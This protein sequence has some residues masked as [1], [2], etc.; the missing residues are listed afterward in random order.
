M[1]K[2][3]LD[4]MTFEGIVKVFSILFSLANNYFQFYN[5][6]IIMLTLPKCI[7]HSI[8]FIIYNSGELSSFA[9]DF[10]L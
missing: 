7:I 8:L 6:I 5:N 2:L 9:I 4:I 1:I 10:I 3:F